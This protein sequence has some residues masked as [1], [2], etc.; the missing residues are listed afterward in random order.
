MPYIAP[1]LGVG[2]VTLR[3][4]ATGNSLNLATGTI[5]LASTP[6]AGSIL[7]VTLA[8]A[9]AT[10]LVTAVSGGAGAWNFPNVQARPAGV[11]QSTEVWWS[12]PSTGASGNVISFAVNSGT[13]GWA[14]HCMEF[15]NIPPDLVLEAQS[16]D[17]ANVAGSNV[18]IGALGTARGDALQI[19]SCAWASANNI[20]S[21]PIQ[22]S[23]PTGA[24]QVNQ[25]STRNG[26]AWR[27]GSQ[28]DGFGAV[29]EQ[30]VLSGVASN[31]VG[32]GVTLGFQRAGS[33][34][35]AGQAVNR[36]GSY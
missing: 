30:F 7:V 34:A 23:A 5:T 2:G 12:I 19:A 16:A 3:Q 33:I 13:P 36:A 10:T 27:Q 31:H 4:V 14:G 15:T 28:G 22:M 21:Y 1:R 8:I 6:L 20:S 29:T 18:P 32:V 25:A 9:N 35:A 11:A 24:G 17:T 26:A